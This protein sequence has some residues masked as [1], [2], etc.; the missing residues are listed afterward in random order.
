[1]KLIA[2]LVI[3]M[4]VFNVA[5]AFAQTRTEIE[6]KFGQPV[7]SYAVSERI[8]MSPEYASDGQVCRMTFYPR[9]FS[10][11]TTYL[12]NELS[13][14][15]F[16]SVIDA[17]VPVAM[18]GDQKEPFGKGGWDASGGARWANFVY[19]K[20]TITYIATLQINAALGM[21]EPVLLDNDGSKGQEKAKPIKQDFSLYRDSTAEMVTVQWND[22]KCPG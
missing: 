7:N 17:I 22:R 21:G 5:V 1:M 13:F 20:V 9:R 18:R 6:A 15:E 3:V 16:R 14:D 12:I 4:T 10:S 2:K 8:R 11:T 19:D